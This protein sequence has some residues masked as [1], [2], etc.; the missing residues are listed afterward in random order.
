MKDLKSSL[1]ELY[2]AWKGN[3]TEEDKEQKKDSGFR[4]DLELIKECRH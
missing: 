4:E 3:S 1:T 2:E